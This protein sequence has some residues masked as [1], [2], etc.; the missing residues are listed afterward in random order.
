M[1]EKDYLPLKDGSH[2][3]IVGGGPAG[4]LFAHALLRNAQHCGLNL[5]V[6]IF[7]GKSF[8]S[9]I[10]CNMCA[11][12][13]AKSFAENLRNIGLHLPNNVVQ[14]YIQG[15]WLE[16]K[17]GALYLH[18][19][20]ES[21][22]I[23][24][25]FRANGP[26]GS[27]YRENV[28]FD[29]Y[30]LSCVEKQGVTIV[31]QYVT[32]IRLPP[33]RGLPAQVIYGYGSNLKTCE[34][35]LVVGAFGLNSR[36]VHY[37]ENLGFGYKPPATMRSVQAELPLGE[38]YIQRS[39][40]NAIWVYGLSL[41]GIKFAALTPKYEYLTVTLI[42]ENVTKQDIA[43]LLDHP[44]VR[45]RFP[46]DWQTPQSYCH[47]SPRVSASAARRP[48]TDRFVIIGEAGDSRLYKNG[49]ESAYVTA[50]AAAATTV[51]YGVSA[52]AF[53][54]YYYPTCRSIVRDSRYGQLLFWIN[55]RVFSYNLTARAL[56]EAAR[57]E[58][59]QYPAD[60][61]VINQV[62][63]DTLTGDRPYK[64]IFIDSLNPRFQFRF[65]A[66]VARNLYRKKDVEVTR[67]W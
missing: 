8:G 37:V 17:V 14:R 36:M 56:I 31:P 44:I 53:E 30:L 18:R 52:H 63:W 32:E 49:L 33:R 23:L 26:R 9:A 55:D 5:H 34:A 38:E 29:D 6:T 28:S 62:L 65:L 3:A 45:K 25:V 39:F 10:G 66:Q 19:P 41:P 20:Y 27:S 42:G 67:E 64:D 16:T 57:R 21:E 46:A 7:D 60:M 4:A 54:R 43:V 1:P 22:G 58:Q 47:C 24:T 35:D 48:F 15:Y 12:V 2:I 40:G 59:T 61:R 51:H 50:C 11:G 13:I